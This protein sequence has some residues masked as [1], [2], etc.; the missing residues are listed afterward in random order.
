VSNPLAIAAVTQ[1]LIELL[2]GIP[3]EDTTLGPLGVS[4]SPPDRARLGNNAD[5]RQLNLFLYQV[6]PNPGWTNAD[7]PFRGSE[8]TLTHEPVLA[9]DLR[10]LLTAYG[11]N[12]ADIDAHHVLAHGMSLLHDRAVL[13]HA[14]VRAALDLAGA[15]LR[16]ADLDK[17]VELIKVAPLSISDEELFRMWTV[18]G[19]QYRLSVCYQASVVLI[20]RRQPARRPPPVR[21]PQLTVVPLTVPIIE[22]VEPRPARDGDTLT[23]RGLNL[24]ADQVT[25]RFASADV[26]LPA[27]AVTATELTVALPAS[28]RPGPNTV[29]LLQDVALPGASGTRPF[30][31]SDV[32]AFVLAPT[33]TPAPPAAGLAVPRGADLTLGIA[34]D[35]AREQRVTLLLGDR[36]VPRKLPATAPA[37]SSTATFPIPAAPFP[38]GTVLLRVVVDGAE[39]ELVVD[40]TPGSPTEGQYVGPTAVVT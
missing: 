5:T 15:P 18:F 13:R 32:A 39:S 9:L 8:G 35:V 19:V 7:L 36:A 38:A 37:T 29:Q 40:Q 10:Y 28:L 23:I 30:F 3:T 33:I 16:D 4:A 12:N 25:V 20:E 34:P 24:R 1:T 27:A 2:R 22:D 6:A 11:V 31:S 26:V 17:Q 14:D 21:E